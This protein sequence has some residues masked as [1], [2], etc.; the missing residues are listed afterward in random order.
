MR[1]SDAVPEYEITAPNEA[2][3]SWKHDPVS[4]QVLEIVQTEIIL[5]GQRAASPE[6]LGEN[7]VQNAAR[8]VGYVEG[9]QFLEDLLML[10][11]VVDTKEDADDADKRKEGAKAVR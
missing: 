11:D 5:S 7:L 9:L 8:A 2:L 10:R 1:V 3:I 6:I 4:K